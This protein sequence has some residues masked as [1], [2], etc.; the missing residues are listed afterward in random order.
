MVKLFAPLA[1]AGALALGVATVWLLFPE[2]AAVSLLLLA[3]AAG[4]GP[5]VVFDPVVV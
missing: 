4:L 5:V 2:A 1:G 3:A